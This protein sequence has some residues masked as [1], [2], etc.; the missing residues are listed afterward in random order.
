MG[1][2]TERQGT[3]IEG[4]DTMTVQV[5]VPV[6][7][8]D[9]PFMMPLAARTQDG[10]ENPRKWSNPWGRRDQCMAHLRAAFHRTDHNGELC[11]RVVLEPEKRSLDGAGESWGPGVHENGHMGLGIGCSWEAIDP[12][13]KQ[14]IIEVT[15]DRRKEDRAA[16]RDEV[17]VGFYTNSVNNGMPGMIQNHTSTGCISLDDDHDL[18]TFKRNWEPWIQCGV[19]SELS[20]DAG[21]HNWLWDDV[22]DLLNDQ[23]ERFG[24]Y[25]LT[26]SIKWT[27]NSGTPPTRYTWAEYQVPM[28]CISRYILSRD[29]LGLLVWPEGARVWI[30]NSAH[31]Y[32]GGTSGLLTE[33][34]AHDYTR[35]G[36][37]VGSWTPHHGA[38]EIV[39]LPPFDPNPTP[40]PGGVNPTPDVGSGRSVR[41][42]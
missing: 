20:F 39:N 5:N 8:D 9:P 32:W 25:G 42:G 31:T 30:M 12:F 17:S 6:R 35:R 23:S 27:D 1:A 18:E 15:E 13:L 11:K 14:V 4:T 34:Q 2:S 3:P 10:D 37:G 22:K 40:G 36:W 38:D 29:P 24:L 26:E 19:L 21:V 7:P 16:G 33:A 28:W 41:R